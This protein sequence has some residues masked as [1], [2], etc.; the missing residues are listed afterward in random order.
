[1][2]EYLVKVTSVAEGEYWITPGSRK[3]GYEDINT[4][5]DCIEFDKQCFEDG[6]VFISDFTDTYNPTFTFEVIESREVDE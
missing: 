4:I 3:G 1:M 6:E 5:E 2:K